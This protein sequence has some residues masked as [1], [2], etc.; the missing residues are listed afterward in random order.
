MKAHPNS[1]HLLVVVED[2]TTPKGRYR[3]GHTSSYLSRLQN[4][5]TQ[6]HI[7]TGM[8]LL[9]VGGETKE[10]EGSW[11]YTEE[12]ELILFSFGGTISDETSSF[13]QAASDN[14]GF[15]NRN[16]SFQ[17]FHPRK[18]FLEG[19]S[20]YLFIYQKTL[21]WRIEADISL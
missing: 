12:L 16:G 19:P 5:D 18:S 4:P 6:D 15:G 8:S 13:S 9:E 14:G 2:W 21:S 7:L 20:T 3:E 1:V 17:S 10:R 11:S